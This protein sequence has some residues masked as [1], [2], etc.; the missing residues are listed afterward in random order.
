MPETMAESQDLRYPIGRFV[1]PQVSS[2]A[3]RAEQIENLRHAPELL[4]ASVSGLSDAQLDTAY[5][6]DGWIVRQ[7]VHHLADSHANAFIRFKLA[8]T[9]DWPTVKP[10]D[11]A[12]W[13][14]LVDSRQP[15]VESLAMFGALHGRWVAL[16]KSMT[17]EDFQKGFN[18]PKMGRQS[19]AA[20]LA[21]YS[22]HA[23]H[24]TAHITGLRARQGW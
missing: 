11:E 1:P 18:H 4:R 7:V 20:S 24:H 14:T 22:W 17:D 9:E 6:E 2:P 5:R 15:I 8:L 16:L 10:Y 19:L 23:R 12:A 3:I 21:L 13:A